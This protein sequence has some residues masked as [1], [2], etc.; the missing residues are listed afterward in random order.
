MQS[1][2]HMPGLSPETGVET[3]RPAQSTLHRA[4]GRWRLG[5]A[6]ALC[7]ALL[8]SVLPLALKDLLRQMD[9]STITW[10]RLSVSAVLLAAWLAPKGFVVRKGGAAAGTRRIAAL[11]ALAALGLCANYILY[12]MGLDRLTPGAAQVLIQLGPMF[13]VMG[14]V[15]VFREKLALPQKAGVAV[16]VLG[17]LLFFNLRLG[18]LA[19]MPH[20]YAGGLALI[21]AAAFV[22]A[23]YSM[24]QKQLLVSYSSSSIMLAIYVFACAVFLPLSAPLDV[25][26]LDAVGIGL[27]AFGALNTLAAYGCFAESLNHWEASRVGAVLTIVPLLTLFAQWAGNLLFPG[28]VESEPLNAAGAAGAAMVVVGSLLASLWRGAGKS[29]PPIAKSQ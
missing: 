4:S 17:L 18:D 1:E 3:G 16:F 5:F 15:L 2:I 26:R 24:A 23:V 21:V 11:M 9:A 12:L 19:S 20:A 10:Y 8:W 28:H 7:T 27:L 22:W 6:L 13:M 29:Q 14:G 25:L